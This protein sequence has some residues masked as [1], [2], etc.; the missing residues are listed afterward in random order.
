VF[1]DLDKVDIYHLG[2]Q[3]G[4]PMEQVV[5]VV[6]A[7]GEQAEIGEPGGVG[8]EAG[9]LIP[10]AGHAASVAAARYRSTG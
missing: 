6:R 4:G 5:E 2:D 7:E 1:Q 8:A 3:L 10:M 9:E